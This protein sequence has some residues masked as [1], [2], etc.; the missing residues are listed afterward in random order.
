MQRKSSNLS[1]TKMIT[2]MALLVA[3]SVAIGWACKT[4]LTLPI[5]AIRVTFENLPVI[6]SG[7][8]YG[9]IVG[10]V[11]ALISDTISCLISP[12][13]ALNLIIMLGAASIGIISGIISRY[14][15]NG[16]KTLKV[17]FSVFLS[18]IVGSMIIK[19]IG[20]HVVWKYPFSVLVFR[21]PLYIAIAVIESIVI[22]AILQNSRLSVML[23]KQ[24]KKREE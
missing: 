6:L 10:A 7:I 5:G 14:L 15:F 24:I 11:V 4:Y 13:P 9:P 1:K 17:I 8:L 2:T 21:I 23:E 16:S 18:H 12:N 3:M 20:L 22:L 19:S